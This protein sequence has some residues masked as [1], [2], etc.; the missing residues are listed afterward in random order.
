MNQTV[1]LQILNDLLVMLLPTTLKYFIYVIMAIQARKK[2][3]FQMAQT[4]SIFCTE[5]HRSMVLTTA[6]TVDV[7]HH[8]SLKRDKTYSYS[9]PSVDKFLP[10]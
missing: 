2:I 3:L 8:S 5:D 4:S 6:I 7:S 9:L 10:A 1:I